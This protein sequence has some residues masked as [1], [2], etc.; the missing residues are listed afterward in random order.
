LIAATITALVTLAAPAALAAKPTKSILSFEDQFFPAGFGCSFDVL[1]E[2]EEGAE[3][4]LTEF[5]DG[6]TQIHGH[7]IAHLINLE[8]GTFID[9]QAAATIT[10]TFDP[11]TNEIH[12]EVSGRLFI[13]LFPGDQG[14]FGEV[15]APG[16]LLG[17]I[18][19][20]QLNFDLDSFLVTSFSLNGTATDL[21]EQ[22][23]A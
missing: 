21:C 23:V 5:S 9:R 12:E 17:M 18:G 11:V 1:E 8:T 4:T 22:L 7:G 15:Q 13:V 2:V 16:A 10:D 6:R 20:W 19:H 14:P 3:V